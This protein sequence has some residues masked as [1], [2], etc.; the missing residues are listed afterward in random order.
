M[1]PEL[2]ALQPVN[3]KTLL[4]LQCHFGQDTI[5]WSR[6]GAEATGVDF[7]AKA[8]QTARSLAEEFQSGTRFIESDVLQ[9][10]LG[11]AYD[12]VFTSYGVLTWLPDLSKW[13]EVV[14]RHLKAGGTFFI[15][16]F[17]PGLM[18]FDF[19][20]GRYAYPYFGSAHPSSAEEVTGSYAEEG[21]GTTRMEYT[22]SYSISE[23]INALMRQGLKL[24]AFEE[25]SGSPFNCFP[26]MQKRPDGWYECKALAGAPHLFTLTM[27][28]PE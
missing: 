23:V 19:D 15:A 22:W 5:S 13:G 20:T 25:Y 10:E 18:M 4:H 21:E 6:L 2:Q 27:S 14:A 26:N 3:G 16:E 7:S 11:Q 28:K 12:I 1:P 8:I 17:H 9:L 24:E